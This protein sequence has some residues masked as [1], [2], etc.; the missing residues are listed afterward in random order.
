MSTNIALQVNS[1]PEGDI[2]M[3]QS[4]LL[5][6]DVTID[7][8]VR[9]TNITCHIDTY[10][11][12]QAQRLIIKVIWYQIPEKHGQKI[13]PLYNNVDDMI[14]TA[15]SSSSASS[16]LIRLTTGGPWYTRAEYSCT[17]LAP[18]RIFSYASWPHDTPPTP[19]IGT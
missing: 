9:Y 16:R 18:A 19:I 8:I 3:R 17:R 10:G 6:Y 2:A 12:I 7:D 1:A 5:P 11:H 15:Y 13:G 4:K 14:T